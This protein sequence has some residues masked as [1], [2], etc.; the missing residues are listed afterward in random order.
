MPDVLDQLTTIPFPNVE[1]FRCWLKKHAHS[2][3]GD[4]LAQ[5]CPLACFL[6]QYS[7]GYAEYEVYHDSYRLLE[8]RQWRPLPVWATAF[9]LELDERF[10]DAV[11]GKQCLEVLNAVLS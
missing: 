1:K 8:T 2:V 11:T 7:G 4:H 9:T 3:V 10:D 5:G 6:H